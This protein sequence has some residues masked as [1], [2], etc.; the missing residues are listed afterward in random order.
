MPRTRTRSLYATALASLTAGRS[1]LPMAPGCKA[2][3]V[4]DP[5]TGRPV[6]LR[7]ERYQHTRATPDEVRRWFAARSP[8]GL[9]LVAG[10]VSGLTLA[11]GTRAALEVLDVDDPA[12]HTRFLARVAAC[13]AGSLLASLVCEATPGGGRHSGYLCRE[14][15][16]APSWRTAGWACRPTA[17]IGC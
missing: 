13:G 9:G 11:D 3:S 17:A 16:R 5:R 6:L 10:S 12:S 14:W 8:M 7:W 1:V 4:V 2:P 15:G